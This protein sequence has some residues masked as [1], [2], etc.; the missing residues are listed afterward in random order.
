MI[1]NPFIKEKDALP[2]NHLFNTQKDTQKINQ[3]NVN[4]S[5][6]FLHG[7]IV[8]VSNLEICGIEKILI[9]KVNNFS[10]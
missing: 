2:R 6:I 10:D 7:V 4:L 3:R 5:I 1:V 9:I 8:I